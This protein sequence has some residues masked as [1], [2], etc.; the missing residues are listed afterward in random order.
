MPTTPAQRSP[1]H[2]QARA[3]IGECEHKLDQ[4]RR[5]L[6]AGADPTVVSGWITQTEAERLRL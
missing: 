6:D 4:Y 5:A 3:L 2:D 1:E